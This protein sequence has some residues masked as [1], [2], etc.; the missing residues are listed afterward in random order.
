MNLQTLVSQ[1]KNAS[2]YKE[3]GNAIKLFNKGTS[4]TDVLNEALN[5]TRVEETGLPIPSISEVGLVDG[6]WAITMKDRKS[7]V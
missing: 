2:V 1:G 4:K 6:Q 7:V 3:N 5:T